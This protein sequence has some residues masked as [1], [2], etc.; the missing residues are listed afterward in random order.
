MK[1]SQVVR[2]VMN[3]WESHNVD[4][5][6]SRFTEDCL[7][8]GMLPEPMNKEEFINLALATLKAMPDLAL[9]ASNF[10]EEGDRVRVQSAITGRQIRALHLAG[11]LVIPATGKKIALP[12]EMHE[13]TVREDQISALTVSPVPGGGI[14]GLL[15][16]LGVSMPDMKM[17]EQTK[18]QTKPRRQKK[19]EKVENEEIER[20]PRKTKK[21][22]ASG[23][24]KA[25]ARSRGKSGEPT[26]V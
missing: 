12:V 6:H 16:Q 7:F 13:Y 19:I 5:L 17:E 1:G 23:E 11:M 25:K 24:A 9:H 10:Q 14:V 20:V 18:D 15:A 21:R 8:T 22:S 26:L 4:E 2:A 3:A